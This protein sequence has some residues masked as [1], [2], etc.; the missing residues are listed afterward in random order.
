MALTYLNSVM[1]ELPARIDNLTTANLSVENVIGN[2]F[3]TA[4]LTALELTVQDVNFPIN[5]G[6]IYNNTNLYG[7]LTVTGS[8]TALSGLVIVPTT[9]AT[10][11]ALSVVNTGAGIPL[12][13]QQAVPSTNSVFEARGVDASVLKVNNTLPDNLQAGVEI[14]FPNNGPALKVSNNLGSNIFV[15]TSGTNV[16]IGTDTPATAL[17]VVGRITTTS[18]HTLSGTVISLS[19]NTIDTNTIRAN[20]LEVNTFKTTET[21]SNSSFSVLLTANQTRT[22]SL[23]ANTITTNSLS[24]I[25]ATINVFDISVYEMS[26]FEV[27][28]NLSVTDGVSAKSLSANNAY[29]GDV[30]GN[31]FYGDFTGGTVAGAHTGSFTGSI[32]ST[33]TLLGRLIIDTAVAAVPV[34][35]SDPGLE[36]TITFDNNF[37]YV[38]LSSG[39]PFGVWKRVAL[40]AWNV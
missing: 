5:G 40:S 27:K 1:I 26:G 28:G 15:V 10:T 33:G 23:F 8:V 2:K 36:G 12:F 11:T 18:L 37:L 29:F 6:N 20:A 35:S 17:E 22:S 7:N 34:L 21:V 30:Y 4:N 16:G 3:N 19:G 31:T 24:A 38:C 25:T 39:D 32:N 9:F 13:V 14:N